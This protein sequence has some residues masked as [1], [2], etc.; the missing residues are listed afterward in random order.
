MVPYAVGSI[1]GPATAA[2]LSR[3]V[4]A[5]VQGELQGALAALHSITACFAPLVLTGLF[6]YFTSP[7]APLHFPGIP[8]FAAAILTMVSLVLVLGALR[9]QHGAG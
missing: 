6:S 4:P 2:I 9:R 1:A 8:F 7:A 3:E 5:N